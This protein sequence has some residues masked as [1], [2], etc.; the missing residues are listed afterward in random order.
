[1]RRTSILGWVAVSVGYFA[2]A[3]HGEQQ[4]KLENGATLVGNVTMDG[5]DL[6]VDVD[7]ATLRVPFKNVASVSP[8][9]N[10]E[11]KQAAELLIKGLESQLLSDRESKDVGLLAEAFRLRPKIRASRFGMPVAWRARIR[12]GRERSVRAAKRSDRRGL[13]GTC[14]SAGEVDRRTASDRTAPSRAREAARPD[15]GGGGRRNQFGAE[16]T[17]Y[18][19]YFRLVDQ[20]DEPVGRSAFRIN[21]SGQDE[22]LESFGE[23]YHLLTFNRRNGFGN[24]PCQLVL[25]KP[26]LVIDD[27]EFGG[28]PHG[29][30]NVGVLRVKRLSDEDRRP[31]VVNV[32]D[33]AGKPL[34]GATVALNS[35][36]RSG[37]HEAG[38]PVTTTADG[39]AKLQLFPWRIQLPNQFAELF[40]LVAE[41]HRPG[42][43]KT[44]HV[45]GREIVCSHHR[46]NQSRVAIQIDGAPRDAAV[47]ERRGDDGSIR[48]ANRPQRTG[49]YDDG[50]LRSSLG[51]ANAEWR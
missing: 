40:P 3:A 46:R 24:S 9:A 5:A 42:R 23:G 6:V 31:V 11:S 43:C 19:A 32:V 18:A 1:M 39:A 47:P 38:P 17:M 22:N 51:A 30:E 48:A 25:T 7:G 14:R 28:S 33:P 45:G 36:S 29:A 34:A 4:V 35:I 16:Q 20:A 2:A 44:G 37:G 8:A 49:R 50:S 21:C 13:S 27:V 41:S 10:D 26:E 12:Q 15:R